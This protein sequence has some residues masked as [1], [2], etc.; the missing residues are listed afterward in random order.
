MPSPPQQPAPGGNGAPLPRYAGGETGGGPAVRPPSQLPLTLSIIGIVCWFVFPLAS[1]PLGLIA[2]RQYR[3][4]ER[5]DTLAKVAWIGG[6]VMFAL[7][8]LLTV[9]LHRVKPATHTG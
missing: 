9:L 6:I 2:Q 8:I 7:L 4:Q 5:S 3:S 1:I